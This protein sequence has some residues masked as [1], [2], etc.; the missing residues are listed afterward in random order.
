MDEIAE[1][2]GALEERARDYCHLKIKTTKFFYFTFFPTNTRA[3]EREC[4]NGEHIRSIPCSTLND[5]IRYNY[6]NTVNFATA[7]G[8]SL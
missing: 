7:N 1:D 6:S 4:R 2:T 8:T 3:R 5:L